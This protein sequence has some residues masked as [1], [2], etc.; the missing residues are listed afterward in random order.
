MPLS[1]KQI[2]AAKAREKK[3]NLPDGNGL[4][5]QVLPS[6]TRSFI[7]RYRRPK[8]Q[9]GNIL[10]YGTYPEL[11]LRQARE[12]HLEARKLLGQGIDPGEEKKRQRSQDPEADSFECIAREWFDGRKEVWVGTHARTII[13]RLE[14]H[15]F[16]WLGKRRL[17]DI[18][19]PDILTVLRRVEDGGILETA[20]RVR[21][22]ISQIYRY[23]IATGRAKRN[24]AADLK[25]ALRP[26]KAKHLAAI[27][28]PKKIG[29]L[30]RAMDGYEG[31]FIVRCAL[32]LSPLVFTRPG[33]LRHAEWRE[34]D[35]KGAEWR[36]PAEKMKAKRPHIVPLSRQALD[37]L[38]EIYP[39]T[40]DGRYI[41][42]SARTT[43]R[44]MSENA[45]NCALRAMG[46]A[47]SEHCA[48][49]FRAMAST[50]LNEQGWSRDAIE[51]QLA[52]V[53]GNSVRAAYNHAD[54]L[55][56]RRRMM[57]AWA[58]FLDQLKNSCRLT[59]E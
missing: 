54:Y 18:E 26:M 3:Y 25:G 47:K 44:P 48:H 12:L 58:D 51:R 15:V 22:I 37:I 13:G 20:H 53:E 40:G 16:P 23:A 8:T 11:S 29:P 2:E 56:E 32:R 19:P 17:V 45:V 57:Q 50:N 52:H 55:D 46:Y 4:Y 49:G 38:H 14:N 39:L 6:G 31:G 27:T 9:K 24:Q 43:S 33:E 5:L 7:Y 10:T 34:I 41:F 1:V 36:I 35:F 28:N 21:G 59:R 42:P 30:L